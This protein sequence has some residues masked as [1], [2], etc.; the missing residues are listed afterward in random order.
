MSQ[1]IAS[2]FAN[3]V[4][5]K[6]SLLYTRPVCLPLLLSLSQS[7]THWWD[8]LNHC[9]PTM[10]SSEILLNYSKEGET[11]THSQHHCTTATHNCFL[12]LAP[13]GSASGS[14]TPTNLLKSV[15]VT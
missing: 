6:C 9:H 4:Y 7:F 3:K 2:L 10:V 12:L 8:P 13:R 11:V 15:S 1:L 5:K 14:S